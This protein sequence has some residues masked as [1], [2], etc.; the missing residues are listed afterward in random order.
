MRSLT[1]RFLGYNQWF[2]GGYI[3]SFILFFRTTFCVSNSPSSFR[4]CLFLITPF[5][6]AYFSKVPFMF[7]VSNYYFFFFKVLVFP[8]YRKYVKI[9]EDSSFSLCVPHYHLRWEKLTV[10]ILLQG[11]SL[12]INMIMLLTKVAK[13]SDFVNVAK[14]TSS[15]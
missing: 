1:E 2:L 8:R 7:I 6:W 4:F 10:E 13:N 14:E 11:F 15:L 3:L 12:L 9:P 5:E